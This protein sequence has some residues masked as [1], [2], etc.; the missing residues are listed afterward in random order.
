MTDLNTLRQTLH[1]TDDTAPAIQS[2]S[3][4][5]MTFYDKPNGGP[6]LA[7]SEWRS[8]LQTCRSVDRLLPL[9]YVANEVLQTSKR[10]RGNRFL[11][12]FSPVLGSSLAFVCERLVGDEGKGERERRDLVEKVRRTVKIWGDRRIFSLRFVADIL[13]GLD[14]YRSGRPVGGAG[15][16]AAVGAAGGGD[17]GDDDDDHHDHDSSDDDDDDE[18]LFGGSGAKLLD[19]DVRVDTAALNA[20]LQQ[21]Q[22]QQQQKQEQQQQQLQKQHPSSATAFGSGAKRR[23]SSN[24]PVGAKSSDADGGLSDPNSNPNDK[25]NGNN[26]NNANDNINNNANIT[27]TSLSNQS[28]LAFFQ[29]LQHLDDKYNSSLSIVSS[30]PPTY[31]DSANSDIDDLV[32]DELTET[33]KKVSEMQSLVKRERRTMYR[34]ALQRRELELGAHQQARRFVGWLKDLIDVDT[35]ELQFCD[36]LEEKLDTLEVF[37]AEA[38]MLRERKRDEDARKAA[39]AEALAR[40]IAEENERKRLLDDVKKEAEAKPG[41]VWNPQLREY[42][43]LH[44]PTQETWRD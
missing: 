42:Q 5:L 39:E 25:D 22:Q 16:G 4:A 9:L 26:I 44:D 35:E 29:T 15:R 6:N 10:N 27:S 40:Q 32:G 30:I 17:A 33:Y 7:V 28:L 11:E 2:S 24:L 13:A 21:Q 31:L 12:A 41:M 20:E 14:R 3:R 23:R 36:G 18:D 43:Y 8:A 38:K 19:V 1:S 37:H 34:V